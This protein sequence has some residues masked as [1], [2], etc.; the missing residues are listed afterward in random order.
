MVYGK[1]FRRKGCEGS[2]SAM[3]HYN[4][5]FQAHKNASVFLAELDV[6]SASH[7]DLGCGVRS[8]PWTQGFSQR[9]RALETPNT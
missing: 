6:Q 9:S 4:V 8:S 1:D 5:A 2:H 3:E 7:E